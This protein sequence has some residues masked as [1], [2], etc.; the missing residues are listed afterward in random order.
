[1]TPLTCIKPFT[2]LILAHNLGE[3]KGKFKCPQVG[4]DV[5]MTG[6]CPIHKDGILLAEYPNMAWKRDHFAN[7][8]EVPQELVDVLE[9]ELI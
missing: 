3:M 8:I 1:M 9:L 4:E 6:K 5:T 2:K 7:R